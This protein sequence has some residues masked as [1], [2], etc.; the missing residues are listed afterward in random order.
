MKK[1]LGL[2]SAVLM[3]VALTSCSD[4][5]DDNIS[6]P[7]PSSEASASTTQSPETSAPSTPETSAPSTPETSAP[8]TPP[9]TQPS[10]RPTSD[11]CQTLKRSQ[12]QFDDLDIGTLNEAQ[13]K[14]LTDRFDLLEKQ[15]PAEVADDWATFGDQLDDFK[16][17]LDEAGID[18]DDLKTLQKG[19]LPKGVDPAK[20]QALAPKLQKLAENSGLEDAKEVIEEN[21]QSECNISLGD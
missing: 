21:A 14:Q 10:V 1:A 2:A 3:T 19:K 15:A 8:S 6:A 20:I 9:T 13:F 5:G 4:G 17:L 11:Y 16:N 7:T 18:L 12:A